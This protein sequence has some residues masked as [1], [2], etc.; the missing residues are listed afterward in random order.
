M[1][2]VFALDGAYVGEFPGQEVICD[3]PDCE[4]YEVAIEVADH[5]SVTVICGPCGQWLIP[6][7]DEDAPTEQE[8]EEA[9]PEE[10]DEASSE[11]EVA[12]ED[13]NV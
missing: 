10:E 9:A 12:E 3:N 11:H 8:Q 6:P 13:D 4:N 2:S 7:S 5:P 1:Y